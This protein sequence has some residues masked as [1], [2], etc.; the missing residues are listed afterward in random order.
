LALAAALTIA[1]GAPYLQIADDGIYH[2]YVRIDRD[3]IGT[4]AGRTLD[5]VFVDAKIPRQKTIIVDYPTAVAH[6]SEMQSLT[7]IAKLYTFI[8]TSHLI[9]LSFQSTPQGWQAQ[10]SDSWETIGD[11]HHESIKIRSAGAAEFGIGILLL[12]IGARVLRAHRK[13]RGY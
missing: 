9:P 8:G 1:P 12:L 13:R 10:L 2:L 4:F 11:S 7:R 6:G 5:D 3:A